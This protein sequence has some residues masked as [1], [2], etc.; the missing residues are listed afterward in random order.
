MQHQ[1]ASA[2]IRELV[3]DGRLIDSGERRLTRSNRRAAVWVVASEASG[4]VVAR[5]RVLHLPRSLDEV[6][7]DGGY[8]IV[9]A[10]PPWEYDQGGRGSTKKHYGTTG[11]E[12]ICQVPVRQLASRDSLLFIWVTWPFLRDCFRVIDAWGFEF[13]TCAF[14]WV[15]YHD[16]SGKRCVGGGFWTRANTEFCLVCRRGKKYPRRLETTEARGVRQL[17]EEWPAEPEELLLAPRQEHSAKP[18]E[19]RQRIRQLLGHG[20]T[21]IELYARCVDDQGKIIPGGRVDSSFDQWGNECESDV[22]MGVS[23][24]EVID[25]LS[26]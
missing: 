4:L 17:I 24:E 1:T 19:A 22:Y 26:E 16:G 10:D 20:P 11:I 9:Y 2:R 6:E 23:G 7:L 5:P 18:P 3:I 25:L 21:A 8:Q 14:V 13:V 15:K 12:G